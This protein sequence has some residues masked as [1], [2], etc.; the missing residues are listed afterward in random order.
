MVGRSMEETMDYVAIVRLQRAYADV[1]NR[2]EW[3]EL[4]Q[5]FTPDATVDLELVTR[6]PL[7]MVGPEAL[8][9]F[10]GPAI[11]RFDFFEFVVLNTHV[12]LWPE[13]DRT[14]ARARVFMCELRQPSGQPSGQTERDD[15]FGLYRDTYALMDDEW[16]I[17]ARRYR[18]LGRF[19]S[20]EILPVGP[21][22]FAF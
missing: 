22:D 15:A 18:S 17:S 2:R 4:H 1:V 19:P 7:H 14:A 8:G 12:E 9:E 21:G 13:G 5:I 16:R 20:G 3:A 11:E 6:P 10:V